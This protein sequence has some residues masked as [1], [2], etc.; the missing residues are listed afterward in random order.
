MSQQL[1]DTKSTGALFLKPAVDSALASI[2]V[3]FSARQRAANDQIAG[4]QKEG[5]KRSCTY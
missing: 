5:Q 2:T 4:I 3:P 1:R